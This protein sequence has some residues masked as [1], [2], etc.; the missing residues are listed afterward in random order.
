MN[1][2]TKEFTKLL[3][4]SK[5]ILILSHKGPDL[6]AFCSMLATYKILKN[7]YPRKNITAKVKQYPNLKLPQMEN[8]TLVESIEYDKED[9]LIV[10]DCGEL[11]LAID[12]SMDR[13]QDYDISTVFL[14]HHLGEDGTKGGIVINES[15]SSAT[16]QVYVTFK[17]IFGKN[18]V[19]DED[20]ATLIQYGIVADTNRF[21]YDKTTGDTHRIF[22]EMMDFHPLDLE[23]FVYKD[24]K[25]PREATPVIIE[26]L[27]SLTIEKDMSYMYLSLDTVKD[28]NFSKQAVNEAQ[29]FLRNNYIRYIQGV[30]WGFIIRPNFSIEGTWD[31]SF[32]STKDY[33]DVQIIAQKLGGG[34]HMYA[35]AV[36][37][38]K[39]NSVKEVLKQVLDVIAE[40]TSS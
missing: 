9:L 34:G 36:K 11:S 32:R 8:L 24:A 16:E 20:I 3:A 39:A 1:R 29:A 30:H 17:E 2:E 28:M 19:L 26:Y 22:A 37:R 25:F 12:Y 21:L 15:R 23:E 35:S 18:F 7:Q 10:T 14:D 5:N 27:K 6:D 38:I 31:V 33:Q 13:I 40:V 4:K